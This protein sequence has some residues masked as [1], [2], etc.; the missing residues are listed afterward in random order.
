MK[1]LFICT[2]NVCRSVMAELIAAKLGKEKGLK[3]EARSRGVLAE[4]YFQTPPE[5]WRC[6]KPLGIEARERRPQLADR[7]ALHWCDA[8]FTMTARHRNHILDQY[9]EFTKKVFV[10]RERA[11]LPPPFD[12]EDPIGKPDAVYDAC[13]DRIKEALEAL[14]SHEHA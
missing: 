10:L 12:V 14:L 4:S 13:R 3:L 2:A 6:L 9:P 7:Q 5:L 8:A 1:W 11:E